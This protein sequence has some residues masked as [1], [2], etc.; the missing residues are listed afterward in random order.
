MCRGLSLF[1]CASQ[2][3]NRF[4]SPAALMLMLAMAGCSDAPSLS[5]PVM[6][7][8]ARAQKA[9]EPPPPT[10]PAI[11]LTA[12]SPAMAPYRQT[13]AR[14]CATV[15]GVAILDDELREAIYPQMMYVMTLREPERSQ[16]RKE[17][18]QARSSKSS[19]A[20]W[21]GRK[22]SNDSRSSR[23]L[24]KSCKNSPP[25]NLRKICEVRRARHQERRRFPALPLQS[26]HFAGWRSASER[27]K[28]HGSGIHEEPDC[29]EDRERGSRRSRDILQTASRRIPHPGQRYL[30]RYFLP[31]QVYQ[32]GEAPIDL[33]F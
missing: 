20:K 29:S 21:S 25:R 30:E 10:K 13:A 6:P 14:I 4:F 1:A 12:F 31:T 26:R 2:R 23:S 5:N 18:W 16:K 28:H 33:P 32:R 19:N 24:V 3:S 22:L 9:D 15:N 7:T 17:F 27:A 8:T 11:E